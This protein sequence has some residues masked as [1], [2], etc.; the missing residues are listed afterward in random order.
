MDTYVDGG[1]HSLSETFIRFYQIIRRHILDYINLHYSLL[2]KFVYLYS[3]T[4]VSTDS[5]SAVYRGQKI[6]THSLPKSTMVDF[7]AYVLICQR[8]L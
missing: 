8:R 4:L 1:A 6:L 5:V 3:K 2:F 7:S